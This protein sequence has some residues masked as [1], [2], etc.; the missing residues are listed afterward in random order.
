[1]GPADRYCGV[2]GT[3]Q[4]PPAAGSRPGAAPSRP[5]ADFFGGV[6]SRTAAI[7]CYVPWLGWIAAVIVLASVRFKR[8]LEMRF[9]A[10]QG[11]YLFV[12]WLIVDWVVTPLVR[13]GRDGFGGF[14]LGHPFAQAGAGILNLLIIA[15]WIVMMI[16]ASR[17][18]H[19]RLP[20]VGDLAERSVAEQRV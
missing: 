11:L 9:H 18:E 15:A 13:L 2:C 12:A 20:I 7:L 6:S 10:F 19:Y 4:P 17:S 14:G 1:V 16:K 8:D 3:A 5:P